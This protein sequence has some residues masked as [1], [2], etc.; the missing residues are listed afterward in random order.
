MKLE[1]QVC[2]I[3]QSKKLYEL[4]I[5][6]ES[7]WW[8]CNDYPNNP[9]KYPNKWYVIPINDYPYTFNPK[10]VQKYENGYHLL[11]AWSNAEL[12][13]MLPA[14]YDTMYCSGEGWSGYDL[15]GEHLLVAYKT[16]VECRAAMLIHL[17]QIKQVTNE[18]CNKRLLEA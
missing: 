6:G 8:H 15:D 5:I 18:D 2:T 10:R 13:V 4:G 12:G 1:H 3:E 14:G 9:D 16:E 17:L 11:P 7:V